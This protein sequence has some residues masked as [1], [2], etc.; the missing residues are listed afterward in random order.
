MRNALGNNDLSDTRLCTSQSSSM[1]KSRKFQVNKD[2]CIKA[3]WS[4]G[5]E[6]RCQ[7]GRGGS[8]IRRSKSAAEPTCRPPFLGCLFA[9]Q[10]SFPCTEIKSYEHYQQMSFL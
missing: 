5:T 8:S 4:R 7:D 6:R 3:K 10:Y 1:S 9:Q 2:R